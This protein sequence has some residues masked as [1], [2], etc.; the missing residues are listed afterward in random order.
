MVIVGMI[1]HASLMGITIPEDAIE[2]LAAVQPMVDSSLPST[3]REFKDL[4]AKLEL[5][6]QRIGNSAYRCQMERTHQNL[7]Q[8]LKRGR[9]V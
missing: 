6:R 1:S 8:A 4:Q 2:M 9:A 3:P 7:A 5:A